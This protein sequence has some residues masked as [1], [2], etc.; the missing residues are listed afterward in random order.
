MGALCLFVF[1]IGLGLVVCLLL[2]LVVVGL[3]LW[4]ER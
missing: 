2:G 1:A 3:V 4:F